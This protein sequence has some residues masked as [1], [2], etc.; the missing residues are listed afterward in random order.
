MKVA[1][2]LSGGIDSALLAQ[3]LRS[4]GDEVLAVTIRTEMNDPEVEAAKK[5]CQT[6]GIKQEI[7][8]LPTPGGSERA[9]DA[10][11][12]VGGDSDSTCFAY[13]G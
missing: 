10:Q 9:P 3:L 1:V 2:L 8:F 4:Q 7:I 11:V 5:F 6:T 12:C 13:H